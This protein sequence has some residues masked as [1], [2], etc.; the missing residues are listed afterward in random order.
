MTSLHAIIGNIR[1]FRVATTCTSSLGHTSLQCRPCCR[2]VHLFVLHSFLQLQD[3]MSSSSA[4][5]AGL[6]VCIGRHF[7]STMCHPILLA[8]YCHLFLSSTLHDST[9][10][11][12]VTAAEV[13]GRVRG[14]TYDVPLEILSLNRLYRKT[15]SPSPFG[16]PYNDTNALSLPQ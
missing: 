9:L 6:S 10:E 15:S 11:C 3:M 1:H 7:P 13:G 2:H 12:C 5:A 4:G 8:S 14:S 16:A